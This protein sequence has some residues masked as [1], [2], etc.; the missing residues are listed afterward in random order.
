MSGDSFGKRNPE[1]TGEG[2]G[3]VIKCLDCGK[4]GR[5]HGLRGHLREEHGWSQDEIAEE[6]GEHPFAKTI[7]E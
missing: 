6:Y 1:D 7:N 2:F 3:N 5:E 4:E